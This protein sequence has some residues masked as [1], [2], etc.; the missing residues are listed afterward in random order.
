MSWPGRNRVAGFTLVEA[1]VVVTVIIIVLTLGFSALK[2]ALPGQSLN[3]GSHIVLSDFRI[4]PI[5]AA[6]DGIPYVLELIS[7][8]ALAQNGIPL[9]MS[10]V[11]RLW[12]EPDFNKY[13]GL[14]PYCSHPDVHAD[15]FPAPFL[16]Y[17]LLDTSSSPP[18][19]NLSNPL[20]DVERCGDSDPSTISEAEVPLPVFES[21]P[22]DYVDDPVVA[23]NP[24]F[25][26]IRKLERFNR[27][28]VIPEGIDLVTPY[29]P[30]L[31]TSSCSVNE[32]SWW[33]IYF[34]PAGGAQAV[35]LTARA[36][37][38][39]SKPCDDPATGT[40]IFHTGI[41]LEKRVALGDNFKSS[42]GMIPRYCLAESNARG[43]EIVL[44]SASIRLV[45][46]QPARYSSN[47][48]S[49]ECDIDPSNWR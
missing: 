23:A 32:P 33:A 7:D 19:M 45:S 24:N 42:P 31:F 9:R 44:A 10:N 37:G 49:P 8:Y 39:M 4:G 30:P 20:N 40:G 16:V 11:Y 2:R 48:P 27:R 21:V 25:R 22:T 18:G 3:S 26:F 29:R 35:L 1:L 43:I 5:R 6:Q 47:P 38:D 12:K 14:H 28:Y 46:S 36:S 41:V 34:L 17:D 13:I 15:G